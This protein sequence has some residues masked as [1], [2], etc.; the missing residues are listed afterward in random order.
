[1]HGPNRFKVQLA[2]QLGHPDDVLQYATTATAA[3]AH[4]AIAATKTAFAERVTLPE[5]AVLIAEGARPLRPPTIQELST[6]APED[7]LPS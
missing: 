4:S 3:D 5:D 6:T 1:M 7:R 2:Y